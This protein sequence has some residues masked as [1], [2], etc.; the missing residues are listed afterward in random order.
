MTSIDPYPRAEIDQLCD[1][2][3]RQP[4][5][6]IDVGLFEVLDA[7][8]ILFVDNSHRVF[9]NSDVTTIFLDI[10]PILKKG[11]L[12]QFHDIFL[13]FDYPEEWSKRYY[14]E[15]YILGA[16]L[17]GGGKDIDILLPNFYISNKPQLHR[18]LSQFW[19]D[20]S[21][22]IIETHGGSFWIIKK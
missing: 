18:I 9:T 2:V 16:Y 13:P 3:I 10:L 15:Q 22:E 1:E 4:I 17:L 14:S 20:P 19:D 12:V 7:G 11:V 21:S 8:D 6:D 5:E